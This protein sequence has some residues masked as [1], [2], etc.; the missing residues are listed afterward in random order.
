MKL[1][2]MDHF[3]HTRMGMMTCKPIAYNKEVQILISIRAF[4]AKTDAKLAAFR[5]PAGIFRLY[6]EPATLILNSLRP[7]EYIAAVHHHPHN[8]LLRR[9]PA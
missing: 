1:K 8:P 9:P 5:F 7:F 3:C 4:Q 6:D 2:K